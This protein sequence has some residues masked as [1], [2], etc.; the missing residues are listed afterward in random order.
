M[1]TGGTGGLG[2]AIARRLAAAGNDLLILSDREVEKGTSLAEEL[3]NAFGIKS[4]Y[5]QVN[6]TKPDE[7]RQ[8]FVQATVGGMR[9]YGLVNNAGINRDCLIENMDLTDWNGVIETNLTGS[10]ICTKEILGY[11]R[12]FGSGRIVNISSVSAL[13]G[14]IGQA[15]YSASKGGLISFTRTASRELARH[16]ITVNA[17]APGFINTRMTEDIPQNIKEKILA[18]IPMKRFGNPDEVAALVAY[19]CNDDAMYITGQ[20][21]SINGGLHL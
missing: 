10:F 21:I 14:N 11:L 13:N 8:A 4:T 18:Q 6:V 17:V 1:I 16:G 20:V 2:E 15:N 3:R 19:L 7:V 5:F 12:S 9:L